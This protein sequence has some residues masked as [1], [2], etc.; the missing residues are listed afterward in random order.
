MANKFGFKP[1]H[2][3]VGLVF[4]IFWWSATLWID[5]D[6]GWHYR[7]GELV[8]KSGFSENNP[9]SFTMP[10]YHFVDYEW[11]SNVAYFVLDNSIRYIGLASLHALLAVL[12]PL[13]LF[14][15]K[16]VR[17]KH[18]LVPTLLVWSSFITRF[19]V[20]PQVFNW[21]FLALF[22]RI[23]YDEPNWKKLRW[24]FPLLML[25]WANFHGSYPLAIGLASFLIILKSYKARGVSVSGF[26]VL[27]LAILSTLLNP[28]GIKNWEEVIKQ[29]SQGGFFRQTVSEWA[30]M[31]LYS[32]DMGFLALVSFTTVLA[33]TNKKKLEFWEIGIIVGA[34]LAGFYSGRYAPL[35]SLLLAPLLARY[36]ADIQETAKKVKN[37]IRRTQIFYLLLIM[38]GFVT[39]FVSVFVTANTWR[40][41]DENTFYPK[42]AA[43]FLAQKEDVKNV[44]ANYGLGG[45]LIWKMPDK[46]YFVDGR[47]SGFSWNA[48]PN[49]SDHAFREYLE[50]A[51]GRQGFA[52]TVGLYNIDTILITNG[53]NAGGNSSFDRKAAQIFEMLGLIY[54]KDTVDLS[55]MAKDIGWR[56]VYEDD[57]SIIYRP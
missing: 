30:P 20:R 7:V 54:C 57:K 5:P 29:M 26:V 38:L 22:I 33:I 47:M 27:I 43:E 9:F 35:S 14:A 39:L 25:V 37:G 44:F 4:L 40:R 8:L 23:F 50:I 18:W 34:V 56:V 53:L 49:E 42:K 24:F 45:Y 46:K 17:A 16:N 12:S 2:I 15:G 13:I 36:Y 19:G 6:F 10:S 21:F 28:Y 31:G 32:L 52:E 3:L 55:Q 11:L 1:S 51:C 48:P 41:L